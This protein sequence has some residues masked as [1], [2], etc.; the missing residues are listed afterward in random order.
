MWIGAPR[1]ADRDLEKGAVFVTTH[2][3][4]WVHRQMDRQLTPIELSGH[5]VDQERHVIGDELD[6]SMIGI[7]TSLVRI[8]IEQLQPQLAGQTTAS[9]LQQSQHRASQTRGFGGGQIFA[10]E[11]LTAVTDERIDNRLVVLRGDFQRALD[12]TVDQLLLVFTFGVHPHPP[13]PCS[14]PAIPA[15]SSLRICSAAGRD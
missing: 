11:V 4:L 6:H 12:Q 7:E 14:L 1:S 15:H 3:H 10:R 2:P 13:E 8:R 5:R 9:K